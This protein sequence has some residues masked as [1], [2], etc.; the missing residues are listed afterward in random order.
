MYKDG[1]VILGMLLLPLLILSQATNVIAVNN[2][3][4]D[5][6]IEAGN[7]FNY[8][9]E[10]T[11]HNATYSLDIIDKMHVIIDDLPVI[12]DNISH[13]YELAFYD[14]TTYWNNDTY[15]DDFWTNVM[16]LIPFYAIPIGNWSLIRDLYEEVNPPVAIEEDKST[17]KVTQ[18]P[19]EFYN[20]TQIIMKSDGVLAYLYMEWNR[21]GMEDYLT[22]KLTFEGYVLPT[23]TT[24][25]I[26]TTITNSTTT[27]FSSTTTSETSTPI[28][29]DGANYYY[30]GFV[31]T[32]I[33]IVTV[34]L[35]DKLRERGA[36]KPSHI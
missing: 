11:Y 26:S 22:I 3:A 19:G 2:Q 1:K 7:R 16:H 12:P 9:L 13:L 30:Y 5:W 29:V 15:M 14:F 27:A 20:S 24:T 4:L 31:I 21:T 33:V 25:A 28:V 34:V 8:D 32:L 23:S 10:V 36:A 18:G 17:F 35:A 6:G